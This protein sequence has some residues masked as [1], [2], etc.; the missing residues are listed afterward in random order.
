VVS[1]RLTTIRSI[2]FAIVGLAVLILIFVDIYYSPNV[3][4]SL[5]LVATSI[6]LI[7]ATLGLKSA[8]NNLVLATVEMSRNQILPRFSL[9]QSSWWQEKQFLSFT[10]Q[11]TGTGTAYGV[12]ASG[13]SATGLPF[14]IK[15]DEGSTDLRVGEYLRYVVNLDPK[16]FREFIANFEYSD[17]KNYGYEQSIRIPKEVLV[18]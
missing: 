6:G 17:A 7:F 15:P 1:F 9:G 5:T 12:K 3:A 4:V 11:N 13:F 8:T 18:K 2:Y 16:A 10:I 14:D